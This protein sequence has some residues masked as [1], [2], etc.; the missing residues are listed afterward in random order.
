MNARGTAGTIPSAFNFVAVAFIEPLLR[1]PMA[2]ALFSNCLVVLAG[3][4]LAVGAFLFWL[5]SRKFL[6]LNFAQLLQVR[7]LR[8]QFLLLFLF[9]LV[10]LEL[11]D[12][13]I[14]PLHLPF[15]LL[16]LLAK[17]LE[18]LLSAA[19]EFT[20]PKGQVAGLRLFRMR[21]LLAHRSE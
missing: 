10:L 7:V 3:G 19:A 5:V 15:Q 20:T 9:V 14:E 16:M 2:V 8:F 1:Q 12:L 18:P 6:G 21:L 17:Y 13:A 4:V 11:L